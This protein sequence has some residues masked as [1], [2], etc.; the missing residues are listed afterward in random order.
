MRA[1]SLKEIVFMI[2]ESRKV[3]VVFNEESSS[4]EIVMPEVTFDSP[5]KDRNALLLEDSATFD[6][7]N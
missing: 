3:P 4:F 5:T 6:E 2:S 7:V 1:E